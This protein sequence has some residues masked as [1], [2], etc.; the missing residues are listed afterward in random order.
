MNLSLWNPAGSLFYD[1]IF[2]YFSLKNKEKIVIP[3]DIE[4]DSD[5]YTINIE[6]PGIDCKNISITIQDNI[7]TIKG[8]KVSENKNSSKNYCIAERIQG[9]F[10]RNIKLT[11]YINTDSIKAVYEKGVLIITLPKIEKSKPKK[12]DI[13]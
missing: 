8:E 2:N 4:E 9:S 12:I 13:N 5:K 7:L 6:I 3:M 10:S 11:P 1:D